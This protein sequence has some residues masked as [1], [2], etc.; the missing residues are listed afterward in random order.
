MCAEVWL[1]AFL[2]KL[3]FWIPGLNLM[4]KHGPCTRMTR[5][6]GVVDLRVSIFI[7][8]WIFFRSSSGAR[9]L[10]VI[11]WDNAIVPECSSWPVSHTGIHLQCLSRGLYATESRHFAKLSVSNGSGIPSRIQRNCTS[12]TVT[13]GNPPV[14]STVREILVWKQYYLNLNL[15]Q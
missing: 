8:S 4:T 15:N 2:M 7:L 14:P 9:H 10:F 13:R 12:G 5:F 3:R 11:G 6:P 1:L